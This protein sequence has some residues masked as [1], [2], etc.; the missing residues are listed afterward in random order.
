MEK[1]NLNSFGLSFHNQIWFG[2]NKSSIHWIRCENIPAVEDIFR[3][4]LTSGSSS[5]LCC[6]TIL[7]LAYPAFFSADS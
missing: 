6:F 7:L 4:L 3:L 2:Q 5:A 1:I